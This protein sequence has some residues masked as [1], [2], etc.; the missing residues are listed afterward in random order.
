LPLAYG[1]SKGDMMS[2]MHLDTR[3]VEE[4][5]LTAA[6]SLLAVVVLADFQ[7][8]LLEGVVFFVLFSTQMISTSPEF[9]Y[10][11]SFLYIVLGL[12][13]ICVR[14]DVRGS[15]IGLFARSRGST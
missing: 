7:F 11:Y 9:R 12:G 6:Q 3:Q 10:Y 1:F 15:V 2:P 14:R 13:L 8:S 4:I 5:L